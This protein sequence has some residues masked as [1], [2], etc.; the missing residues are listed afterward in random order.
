MNDRI[1]RKIFTIGCLLFILISL[2]YAQGITQTDQTKSIHQAVDALGRTVETP[3]SLRS[4]AIVGRAAIMP[5]NALYLFPEAHEMQ[6]QMAKT[7][8][9]LGDIFSILIPEENRTE[10]LPQQ[11]SIESIIAMN[12]DLVLSKTSNYE[13]IQ[14]KLD[15]FGIPTFFMELESAGQWTTEIKQLGKVLGNPERAEEIA[16]FYRNRERIIKDSLASLDEEKPRV[17]ILQVAAA[18]TTTAFSVAPASWIQTYM[19]EQAGG[20]P[21]WVTDHMLEQGWKKVS[22]EQI[23]AWNP[24]AIY[25]VSY[26]TP[27]EPF[28]QEIYRNRQWTNLAAVKQNR[29]KAIPA[30]FLNY[31]QSDSRWILALEFIAA[32][33]HPDAFPLFSMERQIRT[34]YRDLY[35]L[36]DEQIIQILLQ[37]YRSSISKQ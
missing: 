14:N 17:L 21:V 11:I 13:S 3:E 8:Q 23:A 28:I 25:L 34:F 37:A 18:D 2:G 22:F 19:V 27:P 15:I 1:I 26:R 33:L 32:D 31:G 16:L 35:G 20:V 24:D 5:A 4:I 12:P 6:I 29:V 9:G 7:D 30:D 36:D 10:R